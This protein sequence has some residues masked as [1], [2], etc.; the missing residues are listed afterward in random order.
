[1][2]GCGAP[3]GPM[4]GLV[5]A[6]RIGADVSGDWEP[7]FNGI[8]LFI[9]NE[10]SFP[11]ARNSILNILTRAFMH[12]RWWINDPDC[13]LLRPNTHLSLAEIQSLAS[14]ISLTGGSLLVSDDLPKLPAERRCIAEVLLPIIGERARVVDWFDKEMPEKLRLDQLNDTGEWHI[15]TRFNWSDSPIEAMVSTTDYDLQPGD[16][17][18]REFWTG[19][20]GE[21]STEQPIRLEIPAHGCAVMVVRLKDTKIPAYIGSDLH[22]SQGIEIGEWRVAGKTISATLRLPRKTSGNV[23]LSIPGEVL[24]V[25]VNGLNVTPA[26]KI[27]S[28]IRIPIDVDGFAH[29]KVYFK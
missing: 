17:W 12:Q 21:L 22:I 18:V 11:C 10:P 8:G 2:L 15:L 4:L 23:Y 7:K 14:A 29:L 6:M 26:V 3:F 28:V 24:S 1:L 5:E 13:L 27:G 9:K 20:V 19:I 25:N 16:Y